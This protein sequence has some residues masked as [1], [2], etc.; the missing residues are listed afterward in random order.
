MSTL[1]IIYLITSLI[2]TIINT[3]IIFADSQGSFPSI[4]LE[5]YRRDL[6]MSILL[7]TMLGAINVVGLA[8]CFLMTGFAQ[9]GWR[10]K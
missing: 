4:A 10:I 2:I 8:M 3:G 5:T 7:G 6:G 9:H 1:F